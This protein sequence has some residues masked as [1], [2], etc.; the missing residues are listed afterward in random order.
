MAFEYH[1]ENGNTLTRSQEEL[2]EII[3]NLPPHFKGIDSLKD[4]RSF[5]GLSVVVTNREGLREIALKAKSETHRKASDSRIENLAHRDIDDR[6]IW[7][8]DILSYNPNKEPTILG[9]YSRKLFWFDDEA[10]KVYLFADNIC[11]Y[12]RRKSYKEDHV[13]AFVFIHEMMHAYYDA[14]NS[15]GFPCKMPLEE[16]F[17]EYG[18]LTFINKTFGPG[19]FL[20]EAIESVSSKIENGPREYGFGFELFSDTAGG[21]PGMVERY[22]EVSN[23]IDYNTVDRFPK[24]Y[25]KCMKEYEKSPDG[26]NASNCIEGVRYILDYEWPEPEAKTIIQPGLGKRRTVGSPVKRPIAAPS[27]GSISGK[28]RASGTLSTDRFWIFDLTSGKLVGTTSVIR[29]VP[30]FVIKDLLRKIPTLTYG[31]LDKLFNSITNRHLPKS[32]GIISLE[33]DVYKYQAVHPSTK[34]PIIERFY[35]KD[36]IILE[37]GEI[38]WVTNQ[39]DTKGGAFEEF[40]YVAEKRADYFVYDS[41]GK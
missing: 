5:I 4:L 12:A 28:K 41:L 6:L 20:E 27:T 2:L 38:V 10:P 22:M 15:A 29:R 37:S 26:V 34:N 8:E 18:M 19:L 13:F 14:F 3:E 36:P 7:I 35:Y 39:W 9:L 31:N 33:G 1:S 23:W 21:D 32:L 25:F 30:L 16:A 11:D 17:A 24:N 40:L